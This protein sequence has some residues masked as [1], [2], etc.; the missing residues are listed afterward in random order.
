MPVCV[1]VWRYVRRRGSAT[2]QRRWAHS[3]PYSGGADCC[4]PEPPERPAQRSARLWPTSL[5]GGRKWPGVSTPSTNARSGARSSGRQA[6]SACKHKPPRCAARPVTNEHI[7]TLNMPVLLHMWEGRAQSRGR[8]GRGWQGWTHSHCGCA[9]RRTQPV[10][11]C[12]GN[13]GLREGMAR[14]SPASGAWQG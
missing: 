12:Q 11:M 4:A 5:I 2:A 13:F 9:T 8:C 14:A 3:V 10:H 7:R 1:V 6:A